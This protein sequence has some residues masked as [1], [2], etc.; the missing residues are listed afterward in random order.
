MLIVDAGGQKSERRKW[1]HCFQDVASIL[2]LVSL[3]GYDKC[4]VGD[5]DVVWTPLPPQPSQIPAHPH[6]YIESDARAMTI[7]DSIHPAIYCWLLGRL[8]PFSR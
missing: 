8:W 1:I 2:F 5:R 7:W 6:L 3:S 4:I